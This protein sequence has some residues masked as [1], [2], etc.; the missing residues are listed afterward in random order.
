MENELEKRWMELAHRARDLGCYTET[1]FLTQGEQA[2]LSSL[3]LPISYTLEGGIPDSERAIAVFGDEVEWGYPWESELVLLKIAP[4]DPRFSDVFSH[5]DFLGAILNLGVKRELLGD[6]VL[7]ENA[8]YLV[9]FASMASYFEENL[10]R[11]C[12]TAVRVTLVEA[13]PEGAEVRTEERV[14]VA[15]SARLDAV[16]AA[17]WDLSRAEAKALV[18]RERVSI[19][20]R[21]VTDPAEGL[22]EGE[23]V[24]VRGYGRFYYDGISGQTRSGRC[25]IRVRVF[26]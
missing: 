25:R 3:R 23:R 22:K 18:E 15:A 20:G 7:F 12:H 14:A 26:V 11:V 13:L 9:T 19:V 5:R 17:V 1:R 2:L 16:I 21:L 10:T 24:S 6:I 8:G 4:K